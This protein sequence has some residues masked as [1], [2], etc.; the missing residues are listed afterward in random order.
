[1]RIVKN[2]SK[3]KCAH[4]QF[5]WK[6]SQEASAV[7]DFGLQT[8]QPNNELTSNTVPDVLTMTKT[9]QWTTSTEFVLKLDIG[10]KVTTM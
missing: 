5:Y 3:G 10:W 2:S 6:K 7:T 1:M 4:P 9:F 8:L